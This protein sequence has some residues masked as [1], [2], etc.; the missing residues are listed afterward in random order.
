M[1]ILSLLDRLLAHLPR[2]LLVAIA[3]A[4]L[5]IVGA[6]DYVTGTEIGLSIFYVIPVMLMAW[7]LGKTACIITSFAAAS[8][9]YVAEIAAGHVYSNAAIP[10]WN[11]AVGRGSSCLSASSYPS[12]GMHS[13][14]SR[15]WRGRIR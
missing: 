1:K 6:V 12:S 5:S 3:L 13:C 15:T 7:Y 10:V 4:V 2:A 8:I 14:T 9:W 11:A